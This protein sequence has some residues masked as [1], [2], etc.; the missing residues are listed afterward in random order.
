LRLTNLVRD[1]RLVAYMTSGHFDTDLVF[2][3]LANPS[4]VLSLAV[5]AFEPARSIVITRD[6]TQSERLDA[7]RRDFVANVSHELRT[8]LT[9]IK[10]FLESFSDAGP[11]LGTGAPAPSASHG[12][13]GR[14]ACT[15]SSRTC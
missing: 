14:S 5:I 13:A 1:P 2:R 15:G 12:R 3:P 10:G 9:V 6:I 8:P 11:D 7:M 4:L